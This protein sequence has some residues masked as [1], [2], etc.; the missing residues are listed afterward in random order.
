MYKMY[1][2]VIVFNAL[3]VY[4]AVN[5]PL[6]DINYQKEIDKLYTIA[7]LNGFR[8][9]I[10]DT[11]LIK[12]KHKKEL[13]NLTTLGNSI[14]NDS[15]EDDFYYSGGIFIDGLTTNISKILRNHS[16]ALSPNSTSYK[17]KTIICAI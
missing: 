10:V 6:S 8:K 11:L 2:I 5:V 4:R 14:I 16:I 9:K 17:L 15:I 1:T 7:D 12:H 13:K 3:F